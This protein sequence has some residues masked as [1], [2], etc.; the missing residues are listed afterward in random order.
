MLDGDSV[1][2][3]I[4]YK[5]FKALGE[6]MRRDL[7]DVERPPYPSYTTGEGF[8]DEELFQKAMSDVLPLQGNNKLPRFGT[9]VEIH[10]FQRAD[11]DLELLVQS[12]SGKEVVDWVANREYVEGAPYP[13]GRLLLE[14]LRTGHFAVQAHVDLHGLTVK[15]ARESLEK[16]ILGSLHLDHG[17]VRIVHGRGHHSSNGRPV[18]KA[19]V[20]KWLSSRRIARHIVAYAT[21][22]TCDGGGGALYV[23]LR[24]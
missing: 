20:Q 14:L 3:I 16:F 24:R 15:E 13:G 18:L 2:K 17:C 22:C 6:S 4:T 7:T 19:H 5:G 8:S 9:S 10:N 21:A 12:V 1:R 23:L 11:D